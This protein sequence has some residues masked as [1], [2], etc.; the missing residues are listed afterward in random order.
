MAAPRGG[1]A[2][3]EWAP[4]SASPR[5]PSAVPYGREVC[6]GACVGL[7]LLGALR[8]CLSPFLASLARAVE[9]ESPGGSLRSHAE[10]LLDYTRHRFAIGGCRPVLSLDALGLAA[11]GDDEALRCILSAPQSLAEAWL[12]AILAVGGLRTWGGG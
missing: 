8:L 6:G 12:P 1:P 7:D 10:M 2:G 9:C 4:C 11:G 5:V 3:A